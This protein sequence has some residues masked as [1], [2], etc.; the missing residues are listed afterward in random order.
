MTKNIT[1]LCLLV[2][3]AENSVEVPA[4]TVDPLPV[5]A[6]ATPSSYYAAPVI[7][8]KI[9]MCTLYHFHKP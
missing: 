2:S 8:S 5:T 9:S 7:P 1:N 4:V 3:S 6:D